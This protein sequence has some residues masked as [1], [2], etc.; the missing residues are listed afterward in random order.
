MQ[1]QE[2]RV[3]YYILDNSPGILNKSPGGQDD[4]R[5]KSRRVGCA[6]TNKR[7]AEQG[8]LYNSLGGQGGRLVIKVQEGV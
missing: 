1:V 8:I 4:S 3:C 7:L 6:S 5:C 2:D